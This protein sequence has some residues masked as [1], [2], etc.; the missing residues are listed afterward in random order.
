MCIRDRK[1]IDIEIEKEREGE[2]GHPTP[3]A[4]GRYNNVILDVYKR[5]LYGRCRSTAWHHI[6]SALQMLHEEME[7]LFHEES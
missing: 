4:Y 2:T 6:H 1:E 5:Q 3:A 7:V